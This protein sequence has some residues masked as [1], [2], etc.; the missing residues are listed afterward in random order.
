MV[1]YQSIV[2]ELRKVIDLP[3]HID[4]HSL[5]ELVIGGVSS[6]APLGK[7]LDRQAEQLYRLY[8]S[9]SLTREDFMN[10]L[11]LISYAAGLYAGMAHEKE[12]RNLSDRFFKQTIE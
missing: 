8:E 3:M 4:R 6:E 9:G 10:S 5:A 2:D 12:S 7:Y 1:D 11:I